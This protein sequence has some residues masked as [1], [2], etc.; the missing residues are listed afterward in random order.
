MKY[1]GDD[2]N[3]KIIEVEAEVDIKIG[4]WGMQWFKGLLHLIRELKLDK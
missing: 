1:I 4:S 2:T 3:D